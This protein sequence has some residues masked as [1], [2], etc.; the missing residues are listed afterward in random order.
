MQ[1]LLR[2]NQVVELEGEKKRLEA[3]LT[4]PDS[5]KGAVQGQLRR[6]RIQLD[7]QTPRELQGKEK[8]SIV[9][10]QKQLLD[11]ILEGM[12]SREEMRKAP[13]GAVDKHMK[14]EKRNKEAII[15]WKNNELRLNAGSEDVEIANLE[16]YRPTA[17]TLNMHNAFIPG[18]QYFMPPNGAMPAI[19]NVA[20]DE[21]KLDLELK[22]E[23]LKQHALKTG[24]KE[25]GRFLGL[26]LRKFSKGRPAT[27]SGDQT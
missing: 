21:D 16:K 18:T 23:A 1:N 20:S 11:S 9:A 7:K 8:D 10:E 22:L 24:D 6:L 25:L 12:P 19:N 13:P 2:P 27:D 3:Q 26:D 14:W 17:S 4:H 15:R 5:D